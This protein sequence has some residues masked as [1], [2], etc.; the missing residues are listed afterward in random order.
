MIKFFVMTRGR[1]GSTAV[2]DELNKSNNVCATQ[3]L[4][5]EY[6][7][8][9]D[10][11]M[12]RAYDLILPFN[13][14]KVHRWWKLIFPF[15]NRKDWLAR[16]YLLKAEM[17]ARNCHAKAFGFKVLSHNFEER[18]FL[19]DLLKSHD[20]KALYLTRNV[21]RQV[22]SGMVANQSGIYNSK[23]DVIDSRRYL[24][25]VEEF[26]ELVNWEIQ[27]VQRDYDFLEKEGIEFCVITY[28][29][30]CE[31]RVAFFTNIFNFLGLPGEIP[32]T[33][34]YI[35]MIKDAKYTIENYD[36]VANRAVSMGLSLD[37]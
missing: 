10:P 2:L 14:W 23:K 21:A 20:Y 19:C 31:D 22:L 35:V 24:I 27:C 28:E 26:E 33:S 13:S 6:D 5:L 17:L 18:P 8:V 36:E 32:G 34:E 12:T 29:Q 7:F 30:F 9:G 15:N 11:V 3:E 4:F 1:T 25:N 16:L 37:Q